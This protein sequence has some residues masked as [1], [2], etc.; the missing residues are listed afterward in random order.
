[1]PEKNPLVEK[2]TKKI[3]EEIPRDVLEVFYSEEL[4]LKIAD[5]CSDCGIEAE[6]DL[7]QVGILVGK[8]LYGG[9]S[10]DKLLD[11]LK[12]EGEFPP[13]TAAKIFS[14]ID[15]QIFSPIRTSLNKLYGKEPGAAAEEPKKKIPKQRK[16]PSEP[17]RERKESDVYLE[18]IE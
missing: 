1:M 5:I 3:L 9:L 13:L 18:P 8:V 10:P 6:K 14:Q 11:A 15:G 2:L 4:P 17:Q 7:E 16:R 12:K